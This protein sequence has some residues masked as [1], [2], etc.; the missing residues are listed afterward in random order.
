MWC[1]DVLSWGSFYFFI[2]MAFVEFMFCNVRNNI[3]MKFWINQGQF[4]RTNLDWWTLW[5]CDVRCGMIIYILTWWGILWFSNVHCGLVMNH[6]M[7]YDKVHFDQVGYIVTWWCTLWLRGDALWHDKSTFWHGGVHYD[8]VLNIVT[9]WYIRWHGDVHGD[10]VVYIVTC[11]LAMHIIAWWCTLYHSSVHCD[12]DVYCDVVVH[13]VT[14]WGVQSG[15][16]VYI[17]A[18]CHMLSPVWNWRRKICHE[19][20]CHRWKIK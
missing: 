9:W 10:L 11:G 20:S 8:L 12:L 14:W 17:V 18:R 15:P 13:I 19:S 7:W 2:A 1:D 6:Y 3:I 16:E 5:L 4:Y